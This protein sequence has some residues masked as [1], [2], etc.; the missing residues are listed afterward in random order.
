MA[1]VLPETGDSDFSM[2]EFQLKVNSEL[3]D[4]YG[5]YIYRVISFI[6]KNGLSPQEPETLDSKDK[7]IMQMLDEKFSEY[8]NEI[9]N[10]HIKRGISIWLEIVMSANNYFTESAPWK[11]IKED[12]EKLNEKLYVSLKIGQ[13]LTAMLYPYVPSAAETIWQSFGMPEQLGNSTFANVLHVNKFNI[14]KG[15]I[16]FEKI[17]LSN[18]NI[19]DIQIATIESVEDHP[20]ANSLYVIKLHGNKL[21]QTVSDLKKYF[22]KTDLQGKHVLILINMEVAKIRGIESNCLIMSIE[23]EGSKEILSGKGHDGDDATLGKYTYNGEKILSFKEFQKLEFTVSDHHILLK[24]KEKSL[25][26]MLN[27][28]YIN[29]SPE[30]LDK[31]AIK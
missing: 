8:S 13:Y 17:D 24:L 15:P 23:K 4:K 30:K 7:E 9:S 21:Y 14:K 5:N 22:T 27:N 29:V 1:S 10:V 26:V 12:L 31:V 3:I 6:E 28:E 19:L 11:L 18:P 16:P 2:N 20:D 25:P